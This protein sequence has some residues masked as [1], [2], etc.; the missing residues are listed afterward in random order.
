MY[1][2]KHDPVVDQVPS[3]APVFSSLFRAQPYA[4]AR[5]AKSIGS[6][7]MEFGQPEPVWQS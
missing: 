6:I 1:R 2:G 5:L 7:G 3:G 4:Y